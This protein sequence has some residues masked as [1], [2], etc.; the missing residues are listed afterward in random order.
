MCWSLHHEICVIPRGCCVEK[1]LWAVTLAGY[2]KTDSLQQLLSFY[3]VFLACQKCST[4]A[5]AVYVSHICSVF[6]FVLFL[7]LPQNSKKGLVAWQVWC[8][9]SATP[10]LL[11]LLE[12]S[13][14]FDSLWGTFSKHT[15]Q[16]LQ[17]NIPNT[18]IAHLFVLSHKIYQ[19]FK[20]KSFSTEFCRA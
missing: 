9:R 2:L 13:C 8:E 7:P 10:Q 1:G 19:P 18:W 6:L 16:E 20:H 15:A 11:P 17:R 4:R 5:L 14:C 3:S 12:Q